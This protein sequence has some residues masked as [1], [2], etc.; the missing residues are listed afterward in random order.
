M[1]ILFIHL[2][3]DM[4]SYNLDKYS[5][6]AAMSLWSEGDIGEQWKAARDC[7]QQKAESPWKA[8]Q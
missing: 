3:H 4:K 7:H 1:I 6:T 8:N 5:E 2:I